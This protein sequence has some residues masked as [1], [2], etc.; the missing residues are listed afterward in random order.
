[1]AS[2]SDRE[3]QVRRAAYLRGQY[4]LSQSDIGRILGG[5]SQAHVSR[6]LK[7]AEASGY[8]VTRVRFVGDGIPEAELAELRRLHE[9]PPLSLAL[10]E[11][12]RREGL[13]VPRVSV[14][15]SGSSADSESAQ[16]GRRRRFGRAAAGRLHE[17]LQEIDSL[18]LAWGSTVAGLIEGLG[19]LRTAS[20]TDRPLSIVPVCAELLGLASPEYSSSRLA[21]RLGEIVDRE[22]GERFSLAGVPAYIPRGFGEAKAAVIREFVGGSAS[23]KALFGRPGALVDELDGLLTSIGSTRRPVGGNTEE[24]LSAGGIDIAELRS[25]VVGD[26]GGALIARENL[27]PEKRRLVDEL[28]RMWTGIDLGH[29]G[30]IA[31]RAANGEGGIGCVVVAVARERAPV[32][33]EAVRRGLVT[34]LLIDHD[35]AAALERLVRRHL[36]GPGRRG[37]GEGPPGA[38]SGGPSA[39]SAQTK[40]K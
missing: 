6:L 27:A 24:L 20:A 35:L 28:N 22:V 32:A 16:E 36:S 33:F 10:E 19:A 25:L 9:S 3:R 38:A 39:V 17:L 12:G 7:L 2:K 1:M 29:I 5:A 8:L 21:I 30:A 31:R 23:H 18:G 15:D 34:E 37:A 13:A 14:F 4:N 40:M 11:L 26:I